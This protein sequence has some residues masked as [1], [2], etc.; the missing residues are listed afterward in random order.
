MPSN[1]L[2][3]ASLEPEA[4]KLIVTMGLMEML[5]RSIG[6]VAFFRPVIDSENER[7]GDI[8]LI[9]KRYCP[10]MGYEESFGFQASEV[11]SFVAEDRFRFCLEE[12]IKQLS[13]LK[14]R[15]DFVLCEGL[16]SNSFLSAFDV[17][18]NMEIAKNLGCPFVGVITGMNQTPRDVAKEIKITADAI[19][20]SGCLHYAT[21]VNRMAEDTFGV[22][23]V[24]LDDPVEGDA[25]VFL[26]PENEEL[27]KPSIGDISDALNCKNVL[28]RPDGMDRIVKQ[29]KIAA[30][31]M[32]H[33]LS[34]VEDGDLIIVP[35]DR[36]DII[37]ASLSTLMSSTYPNLAG[38]LLSGGFTP[39]P[40]TMR[41]LSG[42][43]HTVPL[44]SVQTD[45]YTTT[46]NAVA[47]PALIN[48]G[49]ERK[50]AL[51]LGLFETHVDAE[52]LRK[53]ATLNASPETV[54]P[55]MF[56]Y[57][58]F[59]QARTDI[60]HIVLPEAS[61]E[62]ILR[63]T[64]I[65]IRRN[66]VEITLLGNPEDI[67]RRA[68]AL[69]LDLTGAAIVDPANSELTEQ[70]AQTFY[71]LRKHKNMTLD[72]ARDAMSSPSSYFGTM[73]V[74]EGKADG[75]VSG[76]IHTTANTIRPALQII[77]TT[78]G[79]SVVSSV[80]LMCLDTKVLVYGD[81][82]VN[83]DPNSEQL[84]EIAISSADTAKTFGINPIVAMLSYSTGSSGKGADVEKVRE[85]ARLAKEKRPDLLLEGP[86]QYDAAIEPSV[87]KTKMP[88]SE[89]AGRATV[90]IFPDL[91]TGNNTYKA[92]QRSSGAVAIGPVLQG[93]KKPVNDLSRGCL[94]ADIVN[95]VAITAIQ[96][97]FIQ[98]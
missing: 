77:K 9:R 73:M 28:E 63:A 3:V 53:L 57:G 84:A 82:A 48:S 81:C 83:P 25:P 55:V 17:D 86:I 95:T 67:S 42:R 74:Y 62:R 10:S 75:M 35:G 40:N 78:P 92:V 64:E 16:N 69:G 51:A 19:Q 45:T 54:T 47:V 66:V 6:N 65:L 68:A 58:L 91:N 97:Q 72:G 30:M 29:F 41:L 44:L 60:K 21:F 2:Y 34:H 37:L 79:I 89:V 85:G 15:Y 12:L 32:E 24:E 22:L 11:K 39:G 76:A 87:A 59:E 5:T 43:E 71:E 70:F 88:D 94:V 13:D 98:E 23:E 14:A 4:G 56:E 49:D 27:D 50:I 93:L 1:T 80:F 38:I 52:Q 20:E 8:E 90:F 26:I 7:D 36:D 31:T 18:I 46:T 33:F 61:D 96:A